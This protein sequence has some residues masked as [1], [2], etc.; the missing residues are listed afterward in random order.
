MSDLNQQTPRF[1]RLLTRHERRVYAYILAM[2]TDWNDA[3]EILQE[4]N[5]RLW[6]QF[7]DYREG[8][9]FGAWACT[10]AHYQVLT[11]RKQRG[12]EARRFSQQ[13]LDTLADEAAPVLKEADARHQAL[14]RCM[15]TLTDRS[16]DLLRR[17]YEGSS[18][19]K[20]IA[21]ELGRPADA[22]YKSLQR[23]RHTLHECIEK[24][25]RAEGPE[26]GRR[27]GDA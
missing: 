9:D 15:D 13:L 11:F 22:V 23:I 17:V 20:Q 5:V 8:E 3:D 7:E 10:I 25:L 6:E 1:V 19:I 2:V 4:T 26:H 27:E 21:A 18:T 24:T 14:A 16:R 12:R